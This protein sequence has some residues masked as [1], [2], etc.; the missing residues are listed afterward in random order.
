MVEFC[1]LWG[2][3]LPCPLDS[4]SFWYHALHIY[5]YILCSNGPWCDDIEDRSS[6]FIA[7]LFCESARQKAERPSKYEGL[8]FLSLS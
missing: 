5:I 8:W 6:I 7:S 2:Y 1:C 3:M 4:M